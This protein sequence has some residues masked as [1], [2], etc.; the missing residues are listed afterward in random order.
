MIDIFLDVETSGL[1][2][3]HCQILSL[4]WAFRVNGVVQSGNILV[5]PD[6]QRLSLQDEGRLEEALRINGLSIDD[7]SNH[8]T[9]YWK[10]VEEGADRK[11]KNSRLSHSFREE[12][13]GNG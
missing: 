8:P 12:S 13:C 5:R 10:A 1:D 7:I 9:P 4:G 2:P 11:S 6:M 3:T